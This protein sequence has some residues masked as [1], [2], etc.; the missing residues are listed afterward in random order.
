[1]LLEP[2]FISW[3]SGDFFYSSSTSHVTIR[4]GSQS[5]RVLLLLKFFKSLLKDFWTCVYAR[6]SSFVSEG[7]ICLFDFPRSNWCYTSLRSNRENSFHFLTLSLKIWKRAKGNFLYE[8]PGWP[9]S[10]PKIVA[11][12]CNHF[13]PY[14]WTV[15][16]YW[17]NYIHLASFLQLSNDFTFIRDRNVSPGQHVDL[18]SVK[19]W[20]PSI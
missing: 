9:A 11:V 6:Y 18:L 2:I 13:R 3:S 8:T 17:L 15:A 1:M 12:I 20:H 5:S 14:P 19:R 10:Y 7:V 16:T 4:L